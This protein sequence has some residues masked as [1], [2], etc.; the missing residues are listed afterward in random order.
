[1][2]LCVMI[3]RP[4]RFTLTDTLFP[5]TTLFRSLAAQGDLAAYLHAFAQLETGDRLLR[6]GNHGLL[7]RDQLHFRS[8]EFDL[9]LVLDRVAHAHVER[10]LLDLRDFHRILVTEF[11]GHR[12]DDLVVIEFA[13]ARVVFVRDRKSVG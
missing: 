12:L 3:L 2:F 7:P 9:L 11:L 13:P 1:M 8:G 10:D 5:Y 6:L 4:P